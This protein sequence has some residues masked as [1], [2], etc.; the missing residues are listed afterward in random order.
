MGVT[1]LSTF[2]AVGM[3][4]RSGTMNRELSAKYLNFMNEDEIKSFDDNAKFN[5]LRIQQYL[6]YGYAQPAP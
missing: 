3:F 5:V 2:A 4:W 6:Q 1:S